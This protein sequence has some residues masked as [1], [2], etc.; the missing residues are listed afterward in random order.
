VPY[1][2]ARGETLGRRGHLTGI[3][4][5]GVRDAPHDLPLSRL[6]HLSL[7]RRT[8][9]TPG[10][11]FRP[12]RY[13]HDLGGVLGKAIPDAERGFAL[14]FSGQP[15]EGHDVGLVWQRPDPS[16]SGNW[17][18]GEVAGTLSA[19]SPGGDGSFTGMANVATIQFDL[20]APYDITAIRTYADWDS[21]RDGQQDTVSYATAVDAST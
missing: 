18:A 10:R 6:R 7:R 9:G 13:Q 15:F 19:S 1:T 21:G 12:R 8:H 3:Q 20:D 2:R 4:I 16:G 5:F 14:T 17:Y 11:S